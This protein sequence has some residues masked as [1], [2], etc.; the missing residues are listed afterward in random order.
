[1]QEVR[2]VV[3][4]AHQLVHL[5]QGRTQDTKPIPDFS[6]SHHTFFFKRGEMLLRIQSRRG[7]CYLRLLTL[8][9]APPTFE[10]RIPHRYYRAMPY[11]LC[12]NERGGDMLVV[13]LDDSNRTG[14]GPMF[15]V[16]DLERGVYM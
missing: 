6:P 2:G 4:E 15:C 14:C 11:L 10:S 13:C 12:N 8:R 1:M 9:P 3:Y 7:S 16:L 5:A